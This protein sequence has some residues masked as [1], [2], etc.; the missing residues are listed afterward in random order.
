MPKDTGFKHQEKI[1][2]KCLCCIIEIIMPYIEMA[3]GIFQSIFISS[4]LFCLLCSNRAVILNRLLFFLLSG[5]L[6]S[7]VPEQHSQ[8]T[9]CVGRFPLTDLPCNNWGPTFW[10]RGWRLTGGSH[11]QLSAVCTS[12]ALKEKWQWTSS[13]FNEK[14]IHHQTC[15]RLQES[16]RRCL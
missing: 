14:S 7:R 9:P 3:F 16:R 6:Y 8:W 12:L 10:D 11:L 4:T 13:S 1:S 15:T 5:S 2:M